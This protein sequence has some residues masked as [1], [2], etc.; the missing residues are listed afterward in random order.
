M[1]NEKFSEIIAKNKSLFN[2]LAG[3]NYNVALLSNIIVH[4]AKEICEYTLRT[5]NIKA[6][7]EL[8]NY[9]NIIQDSLRFKNFDAIIIFWEIC[10]IIEGLQYKVE[11][12]SEKE[13][14][15][16]INELKTQIDITLDNLTNASLVIVNKFSNLIFTQ[17]NLTNIKSD[18]LVNSLNSYL[19]SKKNIILI[20]LEKII[21]SISI[22][23]AIDLRYYYSSK[24]LYSVTFY[25]K[26]FEYIKPIFLSA[27][28]KIK[29]ALIFDCDNTLWKGILGED[30]PKN[31]KI[32][33][34]IQY[35]AKNLS[36][37][38]VILGLCSKNNL[39]DVDEIFTSNKDMVLKDTDIVI[40][41]INWNDK[42][43]NLKEIAKELN[44]GLDSIVFIDDSNF[45][46]NLVKENLP[47]I[48]V[49]QVPQHEYEYGIMIREIENLF[50]NPCVTKEDLKKVEIY[51][52]QI[53]RV[54]ERKQISNI[55]HYLQSLKLEITTFV[56]NKRYI[57]RI[58]QMSQKTNQFN[59]RTK[60]YTEN[61]IKNFIEDNK[62]VV[63]AINVTDKFG[64]NGIT[65][66]VIIDLDNT[67]AFIDTF[68]MSCR[69]LGRNIED[70]II[71]ILVKILK[72]KG[73]TLLTSE[74]IKT[75]KN[76]QVENL[77]EKYGFEVLEETQNTKKYELLLNNYT[78]TKLDYIGV[79]NGQ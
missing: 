48:K 44:I 77:Y 6:V 79:K 65:A 14:I 13:I 50:F 12:Y 36:K 27:N 57:S 24:S 73:I 53:K 43:S 51:K 28:G 78:Y 23:N 52:T 56:D 29:K 34:E 72:N 40:K 30:G 55:E 4:Q 60:R 2:E 35:L 22:P 46:V 58:S 71:N 33:T 26:Y 25:K 37:N 68:L 32:F 11:L 42:V 21:S 17:F 49:F 38:G 19:L 39:N 7:V 69:I 54:N 9:D 31:I 16:L 45:E 70:K 41:K 20:D 61:D 18:L 8:G 76:E 5:E 67:V 59:L 66:L 3:Q 74:Y 10:N 47:S 75:L 62:K 15:S 1:K 64:D 63:L